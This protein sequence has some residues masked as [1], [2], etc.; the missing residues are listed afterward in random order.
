MPGDFDLGPT[1]SPTSEDNLKDV[2]KKVFDGLGTDKE[3]YLAS[4]RENSSK[5]E[6]F[7]S[8]GKS[9][10]EGTFSFLSVLRKWNSYTP[11]LPTNGSHARGGGYFVYHK[12]IGIT[13]DPGYNFVQNF[14]EN[15][16][17]LDDIDVV[18]IT[19]AHND[20]TVELESI[21]SLLYKRNKQQS[22]A[23]AHKKIDLYLNL[24]TFKKYAAYFDLSHK[25]YPNYIKNIVLIDSQNEYTIPKD[26]FESDLSIITTKTQ[27]HEMITTSYALGFVLR[28][29]NKTIRFT[30]DTGW[31]EIIEKEN[32]RLL[33]FKQ[34]D[35]VD[36]LVP[37]LG[38]IEETEFNFNHTKTI[39]DN[40][41]EGI[42]HEQHLGILGC[43]CMIH[44]SR[45]DLVI[46]SEFGEELKAIRR[47]V[48]SK[49]SEAISIPC[50]PG[51]I[52]LH[53]RLDDLSFFCFKSGEMKQLNEI[54]IYEV[55]D[56]L[57]F[58]STSSFTPGECANKNATIQA[59]ARKSF[60]ELIS[61]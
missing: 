25:N 27:H 32:A 10:R 41:Q 54:E 12:G 60:R 20:H 4:I 2:I 57:F 39:Q 7:I 45:P 19:H 34:I 46:F 8:P 23:T 21:F 5:F 36:I 47:S 59:L 24:G 48:V 53:V 28:C 51:D 9:I 61:P 56:D 40:I 31:N 50:L 30:G 14:F 58:V 33:D 18:I 6:Q 17:K 1:I 3:S 38:S 22:E 35:K 49:I 44:N 16:F 52:G 37:H 13:I 42:F 26:V 11:V 29:G 15:N 43:I 55:K